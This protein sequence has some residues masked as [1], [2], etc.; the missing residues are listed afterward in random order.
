MA[1]SPKKGMDLLMKKMK[2]MMQMTKKNQVSREL[3]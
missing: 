3:R 2:K 1:M